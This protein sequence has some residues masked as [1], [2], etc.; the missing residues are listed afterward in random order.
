MPEEAAARVLADAVFYRTSLRA[1]AERFFTLR[2]E[3]DYLKPVVRVLT[4]GVARNYILLDHALERLG[5]GPPSHSYK[6][7]LLRV[8]AYEVMVGGKYKRSRIEKLAPKAGAKPEDILSLRDVRPRDLVKGL[9]RPDRLSILYS[10]P[11]WI[12]EE[13][14]EASIPR[15]EELL[16]TLNQDPVRW[17]RVAPGVDVKQ[18]AKRLRDQGVVI[19]PDQDLPDTARIVDGASKATRTEEYRRGLYTLQDKASILV[20]HIL[21]PRGARVG[22]VTA[23]AAV[24]ASHMAWLG[25]VYVTAGDIKV[26]RLYEALRVLDRLHARHVVDVYAA[27]ARRTP[28]RTLDRVLVDP[29]CT[30]L[31]RLQYE[32]EVKMWITRGELKFF[33]RLQYQILKR[34]IEWAKPGTRIVYSVCTLTASETIKIIRR[35]L[36]E[37]SMVDEEEPP[38]RLGDRIPGLPSSQRLYPHVHSTQG[39][40]ITVLRKL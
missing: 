3:L 39:F 18:L 29:P 22:D 28:L 25:A 21:E 34:I 10:F 5:Y 16:K 31:G 27:D 24:K 1:A 7:M 38:I 37:D 26:E 4:L 13:L 11:R 30:D 14:L 36:R 15:L 8:L 40:F 23:G 19:E 6:W 17:I 2:P 33:S 35:V 32:P 12:I 9:P 20:S